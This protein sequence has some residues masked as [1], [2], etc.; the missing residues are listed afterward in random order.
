M[1]GYER[2]VLDTDIVAAFKLFDP[3]GLPCATDDPVKRAGSRCPSMLKRHS[4]FCCRTTPK[5]LGL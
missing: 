3:A 4:V 1:I 5:R 2:G